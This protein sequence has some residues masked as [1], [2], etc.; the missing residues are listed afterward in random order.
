[1]FG[2]AGHPLAG[3]RR[4]ADEAWAKWVMTMDDKGTVCIVCNLPKPQGLFICGQFLCATCEQDIVAT[5][6]ED[7]RYSYYIQCMK[8]IWLA[9]TS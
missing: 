7:A 4:L 1:M 3:K 9:A 8:R 2:T 5:E 6:V